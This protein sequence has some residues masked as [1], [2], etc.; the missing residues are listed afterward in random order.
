MSSP[1]GQRRPD[2]W[3]DIPWQ[4]VSAAGRIYSDAVSASAGSYSDP[5]HHRALS[6]LTSKHQHTSR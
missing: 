2:D 3:W 6:A 5:S 4:S 1:A